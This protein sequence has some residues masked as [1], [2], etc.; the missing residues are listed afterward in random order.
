MQTPSDEQISSTAN[1]QVKL[2][3]ALQEHGGRRRHGAFLV[4]GLRLV[5]TASAAVAPRLVFHTAAFLRGGTRERALIRRLRAAGIL[6][7][8]ATD[9]V[10][11]HLAGTVHPQ[12]IVA[13][14]P[15]P[16]LDGWRPP[17][18]ASGVPLILVLDGITD[19]GNAGTLLR[20]AAAAGASGVIAA[21]GT[22]DLFAPK[23]VRAAAGAHFSLALA[24][25]EE[26]DRLDRHV[27]AGCRHILANAAAERPY[28]R[29]NLTVP[30]ALIVSSEAHG[31]STG[32]RAFATETAAIPIDNVESLNAA[33]AGSILL[34]EAVRQRAQAGQRVVAHA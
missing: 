34:F 14:L 12:G 21:P 2:A 29:L 8:L 16:G 27:P 11:E 17:I 20:S 18:T 24:T 13:V 33:V 4:E 6:V 9:S 19:P 15:M 5:E 32:A 30:V 22:T 1:P 3:H 28:W 25:V 31:A 7:R 10:L 23:V 26:W